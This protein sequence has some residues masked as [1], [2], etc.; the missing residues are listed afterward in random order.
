M[1][2]LSISVLIEFISCSAKIFGKN[3]NFDL[4]AK[5]VVIKGFNVEGVD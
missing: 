3:N 2:S 5:L 4:G 1:C